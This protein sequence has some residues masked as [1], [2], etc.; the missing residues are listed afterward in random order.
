MRVRLPSVLDQLRRVV[1]RHGD[2]GLSDAQL[3]Q[4]FATKRDEAAFEVLVWRHG[5]M[6]LGV[7]RRVLRNPD[8]A[9]D[10]LQA[11]F[12]ALIRQAPSIR[13]GGALAGWLHNVA[14]RIAL[15]AREKRGKLGL[16]QA[17]VEAAPAPP[18]A[19]EE[20]WRDLWPVLDEELRRLPPKYRTP[21]VL[22]YLQGLTNQ[23]VAAEMGCPVGTVFTRLAR[24]RQLLRQRLARRGVTLTA[25]ALS[26]VLAPA[27]TAPALRAGLARATARAARAF[28]AGPGAAAGMP[29]AKVIALTEG[30]GNMVGVSRLKLVSVLAILLAVAGSGAGLLALRGAPREPEIAPRNAAAADQPA[31]AAKPPDPAARP[32]AAPEDSERPRVVQVY[33]PDGA[34]DVEPITEV[35]IRFDRPMD[36]TSALLVWDPRGEAGFRPRGEMRYVEDTHEFVLPVQLSPGR[37]H[38]VTANREGS[39]PGKEKDYEGF[40]S[41]GRVAAKPYHWSF[42]TA[43]PAAGGGK[44]PRVT[45]VSPAPDTEVALLTPVEVTFDQPMD[46][47]S[48]GLGGAEPPGFD[49]HAELLGPPQYDPERRRFTLLTL[50]PPNWNGDLRLEGFRGKDG[51][52]AAPLTVPYRT[53]GT[54][55]GEALRQRVERAGRSAELRQ[56]VERARKARRELTGLSE[57]AVWSFSLGSRT[58]SWCEQFEAHGSRFAVQGD[59]KFL[60]AVD[61][62]MGM[63]FR[64]GCD[65]KT[66]WLRRGDEL[67]SVP[68]RDVPDKNLLFCDAFDAAGT[69]DADRV[70]QDRKLEDLGETTV[71]GRRCY[72]VRSWA[73]AARPELS[74]L[75]DW[76]LDA[77]TLLPVRVET[78]LGGGTQST[79]YTYSHLKQPVPDDVFRPESGPGVRE[80]RPEPLT[81]GYTRRFLTVIDGS[82][83]RMSVRW[84]MKG[85]KGTTS[86][87]LN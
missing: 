57:E 11:T 86:S 74:P 77:A 73:V 21:L 8:D 22:S 25:G 5:P 2:G 37:K 17:A 66:C 13:R 47:L 19:A 64:V 80:V 48:Y 54:P 26:A 20:H 10:V 28:A 82:S 38:E 69:A 44:P 31:G 52:L 76:F 59:Q 18:P 34:A 16:G 35:R 71:C 30:V 84:G 83:G 65:G 67:I 63:P 50:L 58:P 79:D 4:R 61:G 32:G 87:G 60:G 68:F 46:P 70:I 29:S 39:S 81:E 14:Y 3:L 15:R 9:E 45:A 40:Q 42:T 27:A 33:P 56:L 23:G 12:L 53:R 41:A 6:V 62:I 78:A 36:R 72:R 43:K 55:L 49:G 1:V 85:P 75:H 51:A 7:G 24:G